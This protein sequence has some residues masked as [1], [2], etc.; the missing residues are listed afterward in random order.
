M[1]IP[2]DV[3]IER[4]LTQMQSE[5]EMSEAEKEYWREKILR[6]LIEEGKLYDSTGTE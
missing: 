1:Q 5:M 6:R 2:I 3:M 4:I